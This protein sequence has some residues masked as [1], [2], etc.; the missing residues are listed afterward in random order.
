MSDHLLFTL[1]PKSE[2]SFVLSAE[3]E[4][5]PGIRLVFEVDDASIIADNAIPKIFDHLVTD[6]YLQAAYSTLEQMDA[7]VEEMD[8]DAAREGASV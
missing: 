7:L 4:D 6:A 5:E 1:T 3:F 8:A 2:N